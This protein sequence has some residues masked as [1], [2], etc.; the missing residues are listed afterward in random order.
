[1]LEK[2]ANLIKNLP[3]KISQETVASVCVLVILSGFIFNVVLSI[4]V[5]KY[6]IKKRIWFIFLI[7]GCSVIQTS[8]C[9]AKNSSAYFPVLTCGIGLFLC[10]P[11]FLQPSRRRKLRKEER[12]LARFIDQ[13]IK[14][15]LDNGITLDSEVERSQIVEKD[16]IASSSI[17]FHKST[18]QTLKAEVKESVPDFNTVIPDFSHVKN[19]IERL[20]YFPLT[21]F[22]KRQVKDLEVTV[23]RVE[24]GEDGL[25]LKN[26]I[27]DGLGALLK[28]MSKHGV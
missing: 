26:K 10:I 19:V 23:K 2:L 28:I 18:P 25:D 3:D 16:N 14:Q 1:M 27:N 22:E 11:T 13:R 7:C 15:P 21:P 5:E 6:S 8:F 17:D 4:F 24:L 20:A 9:I 12:E